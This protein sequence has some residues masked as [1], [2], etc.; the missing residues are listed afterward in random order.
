M[1]R[2]IAFSVFTADL[3][4]VNIV[5]L[6]HLAGATVRVA[7]RIH[8]SRM[9]EDR[10]LGRRSLTSTQVE[11]IFALLCENFTD[12]ICT[13]RF[14]STLLISYHFIMSKQQ[15][16]K[17]L[18][19]AAAAEAL[20]EA[21]SLEADSMTQK[22]LVQNLDSLKTSFDNN[23]NRVVQSVKS[24]NENF[25]AK[26]NTLNQHVTGVKEEI[27]VLK[28]LLEEEKK[29]KTLER[30][31][32]L[33]EIKSFDYFPDRYQNAFSTELLAKTVIKRFLIGYGYNLPSSYSTK[34]YG[35]E[36]EQAD[37]RQKFK[38]QI[39]ALIMREPRMVQN[40]DGNFS[41]FYS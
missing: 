1:E 41:I 12:M 4:Y 9:L 20:V 16:S 26:I 7:H 29:Q 31:L 33:T 40:A 17:N 11:D 6:F 25:D 39:E 34:K 28:T 36:A 14:L 13:Q 2:E 24:S 21:A 10:Y 27:I 5:V 37:F 22:Q 35:N 18:T 8:S 38:A 19:L 3:K 15:P 32:S 23:L 30:A